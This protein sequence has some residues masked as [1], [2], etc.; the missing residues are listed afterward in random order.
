MTKQDYLAQIENLSLDEQK[1]LTARKYEECQNSEEAVIY[2]ELL[3]NEFDW[4]G[5]KL[6]LPQVYFEAGLYEK[7]I[8]YVSNDLLK[9][10]DAENMLFIMDIPFY[11]CGKAFFELGDTDSAIANF[12]TSAALI[13]NTLNSCAPGAPAIT[14]YNGKLA[15]VKGEIGKAYFYT[16]EYEMANKIFDESYKL[17][18]IV[19]V[20]Y[21]KAYLLMNGLGISKVTDSAIKLFNDVL[22]YSKNEEQLKN[23]NYWLGKIYSTESGYLDKEKAIRHLKEAQRLGYDISDNEIAE[24]TDFVKTE[25]TPTTQTKATGGCYVATCV[26][27]S[28]DCPQVWALRRFRDEILSANIL[29][30]LFIKCYYAVSPTIVKYFGEYKWFNKMFKKPLDKMVSELKQ[31][32]VEDTPYNDR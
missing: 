23:S 28:Y 25:V 31:N 12:Q 9:I 26:Y 14:E 8:S 21:Y 3:A 30:R 17:S 32:G 27:G 20:M 5:Y 22:K 2:C 10:A 4:F 6:D 11:Y 19:D 1:E 15:I 7:T 13:Q 18:P 29:G 16:E 24:A